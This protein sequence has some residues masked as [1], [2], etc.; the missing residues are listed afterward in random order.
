MLK[1]HVVFKL[2]IQLIILHVF[3]IQ[4]LNFLYTYLFYFHLIKLNYL[5][6]LQVLN[7]QIKIPIFKIQ[8]HFK[9]LYLFKLLSFLY[10]NYQIIPFISFILNIHQFLKLLNM[11]L[12]PDLQDEYK[13]LN[14]LMVFIRDYFFFSINHLIFIIYLFI[15]LILLFFNF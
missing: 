5:N 3:L 6:L 7:L 10:F 15:N 9:Y 11:D 12:F 2:I 13:D 14:P 8:L 1:I 4:F